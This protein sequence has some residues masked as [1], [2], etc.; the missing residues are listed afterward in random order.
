MQNPFTTTLSKTPGYTYIHTEKTE[1]ILE[2]FIYDNPSESVYK[3]TG[4]RGSGKTVREVKGLRKALILRSM[5]IK[6]G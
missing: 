4:V 2:N 3:I 6:Q 5:W 1:E